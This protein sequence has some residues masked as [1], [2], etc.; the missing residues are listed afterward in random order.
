[1]QNFTANGEELVYWKIKLHQTEQYIER[2]ILSILLGV[3]VGEKLW[4][5]GEEF[6]NIRGSGNKY[7][8]YKK[9]RM[10]LR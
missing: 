3:G 8:S 4:K 10:Q 2:S 9:V 1:M 5:K 7:D 6:K